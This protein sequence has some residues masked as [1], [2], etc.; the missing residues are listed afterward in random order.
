MPTVDG[1]FTAV[2]GDAP[3]GDNHAYFLFCVNQSMWLTGNTAFEVSPTFEGI[4]NCSTGNFQ[5]TMAEE[6]LFSC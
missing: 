5:L 2:Q 4:W 6:G 1:S 3:V